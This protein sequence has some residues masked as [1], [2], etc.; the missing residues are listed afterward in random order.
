MPNMRL[1]CTRRQ[2][3]YNPL[4]FLMVTVRDFVANR[5]RN[6]SSFGHP[7]MFPDRFPRVATWQLFVDKLPPQS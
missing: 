4:N 2:N 6:V 3:P 5:Y 7:A 1:I